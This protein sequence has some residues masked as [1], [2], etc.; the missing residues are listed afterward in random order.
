MMFTP[1]ID[2]CLPA[3]RLDEL[4]RAAST[5]QAQN[6]IMRAALWQIASSEPVSSVNLIKLAIDAL[7]DAN[8]L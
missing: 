8:T 3:G 2:V 6:R 5:L 4:Q 1:Q 7:N